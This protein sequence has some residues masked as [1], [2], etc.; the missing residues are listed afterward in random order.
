MY[1]AEYGPLWEAK[2]REYLVD[3]RLMPRQT[4][5]LLHCDFYTVNKYAVKLGLWADGMVTSYTKKKKVV[6]ARL[7]KPVLSFDEERVEYRNRWRQ[8][9]VKNPGA[10][11]SVLFSLD[12][13]AY[14]WL[15]KNDLEWY[16][17]Q[18]PPA[19]YVATDW[20]AKDQDCLVKV[21][22]AIRFL[23]NVKDKPSRISIGAVIRSTGLHLLTKEKS[24][25]RLPL[26]AAYLS[27]HLETAEQWRK[28][29]IRW[30]VKTIYAQSGL[31]TPA[32]ILIKSS[33]SRGKFEPLKSYALECIAE[34]QTV[35][36]RERY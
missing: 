12:P 10:I 26:T 9:M 22:S 29:K 18:S 14:S 4:C 13:K 5:E 16:E 36:K 2:L 20:D 34:L 28:R 23:Q 25:E 15:R 17:R 7:E 30:A 32:K 33:I 19:K 1:I 21:Q 11:R 31:L 8:L 24:M 27:V 35:T 3:Q 6:P